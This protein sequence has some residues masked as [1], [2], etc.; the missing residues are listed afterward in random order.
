M[1]QAMLN[2]NQNP[3]RNADKPKFLLRQILSIFILL[4]SFV[5]AQQKGEI[6]GIVVDGDFGE[7]M[8]GANV[9][10]DGTTM[11]AATDIEG[12]YT[13]SNVAGGEYTVVFSMIGYAKKSVTNV[14]VESGKVVKLDITMSMESIQTDEVVITAKSVQDSEAGLL[15]KRQK[16]VSVS[17]AISAEQISRTGSSDAADAVKQVVGASVVDGKYVFVRGLGE[18]YS[19]TQLN[20]AE[21]PSS[22]PDKKAFQLDL[23]PANLLENITTIKTFTPDKPGN[24]SG[25]IV[26]VGTK[27]FPEKFTF[28]LSTGASYNTQTTGNDGYLTYSGGNTDWLGYDDGTREIPAVLNGDVQTINPVVARFDADKAQQLDTYS[29]AFNNTMDIG[30]ETAPVNNSFSLSIG[31]KVATGEESSFGYLGSFTYGRNFSFYENGEIGRYTLT[32]VSTEELNNELLLNDNK[33]TTEA[34]LGGLVSAAYNITSEHQVGGNVF[35]SRSG[36]QTTRYQYGKWPHQFG[37][38]DP[39]TVYNRVL[40]YQERDIVSYQLRGDHYLPF[41]LNSQFDWSAAFAT[42]NQ[43]EPDRRLIFSYENPQDDGTTT[44]NIVGSN[45]DDPSRYFRKLTDN[46][47]TFQANLAIPFEQWSGL[48]SKLKIGGYY[49]ESDRAFEERIF[50]Y[51]IPNNFVI[52]DVNGDLTQLFSNE[53]NG[54]TE[55]DSSGS[56]TRYYF[57]NT[58]E[59]ISKPKNNYDAD[60]TISAY[61]GMLELPILKNFKLIGGARY[62][63]TEMNVVSK[64]TTKDKGLIDEKDLLPSLNLVYQL[65]ENMNLRFAATKTLARPNFRE[66]APFASKDFV[67]GVE[68][69][70]NP[71]LKRTLIENLDLRWEWFMR[72]GEIAAVSFFYKNLRNPIEIGYDEGSTAANQ[73]V[74]YTNVDLAI[75]KGIEVEFRNRL[76]YIHPALSDFSIG[77]N[78]S[79]I[80]SRIDIPT[81]EL[82]S[83]RAIDSTASGTRDLQGQSKVIFN[84]DLSYVNYD[85]GTSVNLHY[86]IFSERLAQIT[87]GINPDVYEQPTPTLDLNASQDLPY[88]F[89]LK[90]GVRNLL[91]AEYKQIYRH[92]GQEYIYQSYTRGRTVSLGV[93]YKI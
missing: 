60:Q 57:G 41:M 35:Y 54:I 70:G 8:I 75:L 19:A 50:S 6:T 17:D 10:I 61:Y 30:K 88:N 80:D 91:N 55:V 38:D 14:K 49:Q 40:E 81:D 43:N 7:P 93:S 84:L 21:L 27:N 59:D 12:R 29:K 72:P 13:I 85:F 47:N 89:Q 11:G 65:S 3:A 76:D 90:L 83:R 39:R 45:F 87:A 52:N 79:L 26:D 63:V 51:N 18:R 33:A 69:V 78:L 58:I 66:K 9:F 73:I 23:L 37:V 32:G 67:N 4:T 20:G 62:E 25:G 68:V 22:D 56:R 64:D 74:T 86:N 5:L 53:Y 2:T 77:G 92:N 46:A 71:N 16:S 48:K 42:T 24:F 28:S 34:S 36:T 1:K 15:I 31:N 82:A 44:Y